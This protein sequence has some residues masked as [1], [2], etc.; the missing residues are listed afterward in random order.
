MRASS[1]FSRSLAL[2]P[3]LQSSE[4]TSAFVVSLDTV[5]TAPHPFCWK[6]HVRRL[7][8]LVIC[9]A[10]RPRFRLLYLFVRNIVGGWGWDFLHLHLHFS[11]P[12]FLCRLSGAPGALSW[13]RSWNR[14]VEFCVFGVVLV[15]FLVFAA[16]LQVFA[17]RPFSKAE[18]LPVDL[19][20]AWLVLAWLSLSVQCSLHCSLSVSCLIATFNQLIMKKHFN[21]FITINGSLRHCVVHSVLISHIHNRA[22]WLRIQPFGIFSFGGLATFFQFGAFVRF[23]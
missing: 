3:G 5:V 7:G 22:H 17:T 20:L 2:E 23:R 6:L 21:F 10:R 16:C 1:S 11:W 12:V 4:S 19:I 18:L 8:R 9:S 14:H 15:V 13:S